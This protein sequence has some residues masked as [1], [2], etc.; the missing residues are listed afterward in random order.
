MKLQVL[1]LMLREFI[2]IPYGYIE[3]IIGKEIER[4]EKAN[5]VLLEIN[6]SQTNH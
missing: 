3:I 6:D 4:Q 1:I 2:N 5:M